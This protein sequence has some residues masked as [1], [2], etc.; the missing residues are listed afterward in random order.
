MLSK[1]EESERAAAADA[2]RDE[3]VATRGAEAEARLRRAWGRSRRQRFNELMLGTAE[4]LVDDNPTHALATLKRLDPS[5][6]GWITP[7]RLIAGRGGDARGRGAPPP[8]RAGAPSPIWSPTAPETGV[9][10][11][12]ASKGVFV[13]GGAAQA[14]P[15]DPFEVSAL[16]MSE[17]GRVVAAA[18]SDGMVRVWKDAAQPPVVWSKHGAGATAVAVSADG[19]TLAAGGADGRV[20]VGGVGARDKQV[21]RDHKGGGRRGGA[22]GGREDPR[23]HRRGQAA[24][25]RVP[26]GA[27]QVGAAAPRGGADQGAGVL[28]GGSVRGLPWGRRLDLA[29]AYGRAA[30]CVAAHRGGGHP[31]R[32]DTGRGPA[33]RVRSRAAA[34]RVRGTG[35]AGARAVDAGRDGAGCVGGRAVGAGGGGRSVDPAVEGAAGGRSRRIS[36]ATRSCWRWGTR[37]WGAGLRSGRRRG[38]CG[39]G[40][41]WRTRRLRSGSSWA[42]CMR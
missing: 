11:A 37:R 36:C 6:A 39:C 33:R 31:L 18:G 5:E 10:F 8:G 3:F 40:I 41:W 14:L 2:L 26:R 15:G 21:S 34:A 29:G 16:S 9:A 13:D 4:E 1:L 19:S 42:G 28:G 27:A 12:V 23:L 38:S 17:D 30:R 7:A 32:V 25:D 22:V 24:A 20:I 35:A